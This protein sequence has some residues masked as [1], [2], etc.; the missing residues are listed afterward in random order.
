MSKTRILVDRMPE[1][2]EECCFIGKYGIGCS[3]TDGYCDL[4]VGKECNKLVAPFTFETEEERIVKD[5][6][7][8]LAI[9]R[10]FGGDG[11]E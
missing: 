9:D 8:R 3:L 7:R 6:E 11:Y 5:M 2:H 4:V 1:T 10:M